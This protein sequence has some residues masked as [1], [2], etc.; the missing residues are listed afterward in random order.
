[1]VEDATENIDQE[2]VIEENGERYIDAD[3]YSGY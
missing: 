3:S 2:S 1:M